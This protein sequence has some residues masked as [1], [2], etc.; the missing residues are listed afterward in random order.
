VP[1]LAWLAY[2]L[3]PSDV[4]AARSV[5]VLFLGL[6]IAATYLLGWQLAGSTAGLVAA[7]AFRSAPFV[8]F[9]MLRFPCATACRSGW[10]RS[11]EGDPVAAVAGVGEPVA[12]DAGAVRIGAR[13][14]EGRTR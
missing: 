12:I 7:L 1:C 5:I 3:G 6:G 13:A 2:R 10:G 4:A 14:R 11:W 9:S 8:L